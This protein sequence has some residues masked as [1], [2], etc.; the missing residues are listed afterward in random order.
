MHPIWKR[1]LW[2]GLQ[3]DMQYSSFRTRWVHN[4]RTRLWLILKFVWEC[5]QPYNQGISCLDLGKEEEVHRPLLD[6]KLIKLWAGRAQ[7]KDKCILVVIVL[8]NQQPFTNS[9]IHYLPGGENGIECLWTYR[10]EGNDLT[11]WNNDG[12]IGKHEERLAT[13]LIW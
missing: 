11:N 4:F 8:P 12:H 10:A 1:V 9:M 3:K 6:W 5:W 2:P 13:I 7:N